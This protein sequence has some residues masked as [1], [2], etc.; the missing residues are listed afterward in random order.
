MR[1]ARRVGI[2]VNG[3]RPDLTLVIDPVLAY[4]SFLGGSNSDVG[5]A[6]AVDANDN[7]YLTGETIST[8]FPT[9]NAEQPANA[10]GADAFVTKLDPTGTVELFSS[11]LGG[12][13]QENDF[14]AGVESSG[15]AVDSAGNVY[16]AGRTN[17]IDFPVSHALFSSYQGGDEDGFVAKLSADGST[18]L[19][20]T[21]L[22]GE[23]NDSANGLAVDA[24]GNIYVTGG[25]KSVQDFPI[26]PGAFQTASGGGT[27][28]FIVKID[29][30]QAGVA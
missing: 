24:A 2:E 17:S 9:A 3:Y 13:G 10:G 25:T 5:H 18:L 22:G 20:S 6:V 4:S 27:D 21:Y 26:S 28:A 1:S 14:H 23:N 12:S 11:Y 16:L 8:D 19:Y 7:V 30:T 15:V 29:P